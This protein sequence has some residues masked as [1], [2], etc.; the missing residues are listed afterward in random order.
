MTIKRKKRITQVLANTDNP[1][2]SHNSFLPLV[3]SSG[4]IHVVSALVAASNAASRNML[5]PWHFMLARDL[6]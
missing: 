2:Q 4:E 3:H 1:Y 6:E 5:N